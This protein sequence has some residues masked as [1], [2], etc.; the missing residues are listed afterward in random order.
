MTQSQLDVGVVPELLPRLKIFLTPGRLL[1]MSGL[2]GVFI[3]FASPFA[4]LNRGSE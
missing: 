1:G 4:Y 2:K 3:C